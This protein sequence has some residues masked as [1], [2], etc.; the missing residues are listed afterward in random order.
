MEVLSPLMP[1]F[2]FSRAQKRDKYISDTFPLLLFTNTIMKRNLTLWFTWRKGLKSFTFMWIIKLVKNVKLYLHIQQA[3][4]LYLGKKTSVNKFI[5]FSS[6]CWITISALFA[7]YERVS[8]WFGCFFLMCL[9]KFLFAE[10]LFSQSLHFTF[11]CVVLCFSILWCSGKDW[12]LSAHL[13]RIHMNIPVSSFLCLNLTW[14]TKYPFT[15]V[16]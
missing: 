14:S 10:K 16:L 3:N 9:L 2:L 6:H 5:F 1:S 12:G 4:I 15:I 7:M 8:S 13:P 11:T